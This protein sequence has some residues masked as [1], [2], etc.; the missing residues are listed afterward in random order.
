VAITEAPPR[1]GTRNPMVLAAIG[2]GIAWL[3][4]ILFWS[5]APFALTF[6]D[7]WYYAEIGKNLAHGHGSTFDT[8]NET[9]GYHPLWQAICVLPRL[10]GLDGTAAMRAQLA[11]QLACWTA[12]VVLVV[13]TVRRP[14]PILAVAV[15]LVAGNPY[16][17][18]CVGS[19]L[20]SG[21]V[22]LVGALLLT[23]ASDLSLTDEEPFGRRRF[24]ALLAL[25][26]LARTDGA[27]L[28][29]FAAA[30]LLPDVVRLGEVGLRRLAQLLAAPVITMAVYVLANQVVFG[31]PLQISG[32][33]KRVDVTPVLAV[34]VVGVVIGALVLGRRLRRL[35]PSEKFPELT[36]FLSSTGWYASFCVGIVGYY[37]LLSSQQWLW[38]FAPLVLYAVALLAHG[39]A[40]LLEGARAEGP[41]SLRSIQAILLVPLVGGFVFLGRQFAD[42]QLRSIQEANRDA[43]HWISDNL[44]E[45]AVVASWDA[46]ALGSFTDQPVVNLDG[47]VNSDAF[48]DAMDEGRGGEFLRHAGV[49]HIANHGDDIDGDD[50]EARVLVDELYHDGSGTAM[51]LVHAGSFVYA[52]STTRGGSGARDMAVFVYELPDPTAVSGD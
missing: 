10:V 33:I 7:A 18:R 47:V 15:A 43:G 41:R 39:G 45:D 19:G 50:P 12:A 23:R 20:E 49:T 14:S 16:V 38:Y 1:T 48:A 34:L 51:V 28:S 9:N 30:W 40:D 24:G 42:P 26:F 46:G 4:V 22:V 13:R 17:L 21:L 35:G 52:G 8:I 29:F 44:P 6:D 5:D 32:D 2:A 25:A 11:I 31:R 27:L 36:G 37:V 3:V